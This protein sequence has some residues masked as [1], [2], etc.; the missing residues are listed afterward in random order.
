[1]LQGLAIAGSRG[2]LRAKV[3]PVHIESASRHGRREKAKADK[4]DPKVEALRAQA[5]HALRDAEQAQRREEFEFTR[6]KRDVEKASRQLERAREALKSAQDVLEQAERAADQAE[7][8]REAA[9]RRAKETERL[10]AIA[11]RH[12][13][14][15]NKR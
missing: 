2:T 6:S 13:E 3:E 12:F 7:Q 15:I 4:P 10:L 14:T 9:G 5:T 8:A 11:R 1:M